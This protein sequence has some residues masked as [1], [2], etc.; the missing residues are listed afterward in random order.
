MYLQYFLPSSYIKF[1]S[2]D[3]IRIRVF[4]PAGVMG[5]RNV[6]MPRDG[7]SMPAL[8]YI[9]IGSERIKHP[10]TDAHTVA[11]AEEGAR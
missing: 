9:V 5:V 4:G 1:I 11:I 10:K 6:N 3:E 2:N 7:V 8:R